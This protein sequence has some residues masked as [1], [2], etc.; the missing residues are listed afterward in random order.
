MNTQAALRADQI[1]LQDVRDFEFA[2]RCALYDVALEAIAP[3]HHYYDA[4]VVIHV[5][6]GFLQFNAAL[7][8]EPPEIHEHGLRQYLVQ[9][10]L[11]V[12]FLGTM[13]VLRPHALELDETLRDMLDYRNP[14]ARELLIAQAEGFVKVWRVEDTLERLQRGKVTG[15]QTDNERRNLLM[16]V[17]RE[18]A[19]RE[20]IAMAFMRDFGWKARLR[21]L[22]RDGRI[23]FDANSPDVSVLFKTRELD[24]IR[25]ALEQERGTENDVNNVRDAAALAALALMLKKGQRVRFYSETKRLRATILGHADVRMLLTEAHNSPGAPE[26]LVLRNTLYLLLRANFSALSFGGQRQDVI[27]DGEELQWLAN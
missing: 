3:V 19:P 20:F 9:A 12:G 2:L 15:E 8:F 21:H 17:L 18:Q 26:A 13:H 10:L 27:A 25:A 4:D 22:W 6:Q 1:R 14:Q 11:A 7:E 16:Q 24:V 5:I 23:A